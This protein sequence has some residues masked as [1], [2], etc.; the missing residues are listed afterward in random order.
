MSDED[1]IE[2]AAQRYEDYHNEEGEFLT[3]EEFPDVGFLIGNVDGITYSV[4]EDGKEV[5]Y[6]HDF[7]DRPALAVSHD[8]R[9]LYIL[10]GEY[11][12]TD[13]GIVDD[14]APAD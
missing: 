10:R 4:I 1:K 14:N 7:H 12:F 11:K 5:T 9:N 3:V 6:H 13:R 8:G 2:E